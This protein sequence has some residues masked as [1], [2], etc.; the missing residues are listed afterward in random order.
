MRKPSS[1][2]AARHLSAATLALPGAFSNQA[3]KKELFSSSSVGFRSVPPVPHAGNCGIPS[4]YPSRTF[5]SPCA[6]GL[7]FPAGEFRPV[8]SAEAGPGVVLLPALGAD[9]HFLHQVLGHHFKIGSVL[10]PFRRVLQDPVEQPLMAL[11]QTPWFWFNTA[12][13]GAV[14]RSWMHPSSPRPLLS[15]FSRCMCGALAL[16]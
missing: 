12:D 9:T 3:P 13:H 4:F 6:T 5:S 2:I 1:L 14:I 8:S 15:R 16:L 7:Y 10:Q 11:M